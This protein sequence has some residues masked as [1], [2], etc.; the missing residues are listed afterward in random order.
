M[1]VNKIT[2]LRSYLDWLDKA[3][4]EFELYKN[5]YGVYELSNC[6]LTLNAL[7]EWIEKSDSAPDKLKNIATEKLIIMKGNDNMFQLDETKLDEIDHQIRLI[8]VFCNHSKHGEKKDKLEEII[9]SAIFPMT[10]PI[11]FDHLKVGNENV[12]VEPI[13]ESII[14]FWESAVNHA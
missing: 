12:K 14:S 8:R 13:I 7:P 3:K 4:Y 5:N 6:F 11:K 1:K 9:M 2:E 10:F